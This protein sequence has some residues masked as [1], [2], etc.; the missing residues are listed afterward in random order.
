L[1][2]LAR[3]ALAGSP[4]RLETIRKLEA[5]TTEGMAGRLAFNESLRQRLELF[6]ATKDNL[7][8]LTVYLET[9]I[10]P[11]LLAQKDWLVQNKEHIYV[12]SGGFEEYIKPIIASLGLRADHVHANRF[13]YDNDVIIGYDQTKLTSQAGGKATQVHALDLP[14]PIIVIGDGYTDYEIR[15]NGEADEFW[16]FTAH[17]RRPEVIAKADRTIS[18]FR[19]LIHVPAGR[20]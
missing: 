3:L 16:A 15:A 10:T 19:S 6:Q 17:V 13:T 14:R 7:I 2:E 11:S 20:A 9:C 5:L 8:A 1:D 4:N 18:S 12:V